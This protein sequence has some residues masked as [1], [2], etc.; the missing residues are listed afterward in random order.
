MENLL[1]EKI[2]QTMPFWTVV[3]IGIMFVCMKFYYTRFKKIEDK[4]DHADC[5][6]HKRIIGNNSK[7]SRNHERRISELEITLTALGFKRSGS[8]TVSNSPR[9]LNEN[10][11]KVFEEIN[12]GKILEKNKDRL[13]NKITE[14][15]PRNAF[16]VESFSYLSLLEDSIDEEYFDS[17]KL[18]IYNNPVVNG[19]DIDLGIVCTIMSIT[20]RDMYLKAHPEIIVE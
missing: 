18:Y 20:L 13:M 4:V 8:M 7:S 1:L 10:G 14:R 12:G 3:I 2:A 16:D 6:E 17:V 11:K 15:K 5:K 19:I 9:V